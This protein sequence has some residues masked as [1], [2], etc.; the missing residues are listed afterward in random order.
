MTNSKPNLQ[1]YKLLI[2]NLRIRRYEKIV[3]KISDDNIRHRRI[4]K[5]VYISEEKSNTI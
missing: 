3:F 5:S 1:N 4:C 2:R